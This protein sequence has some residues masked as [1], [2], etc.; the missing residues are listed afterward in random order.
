MTLFARSAGHLHRW[1][2]P[3]AALML[4]SASDAISTGTHR[5]GRLTRSV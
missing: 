2:N 3:I 1:L 5:T 4:I